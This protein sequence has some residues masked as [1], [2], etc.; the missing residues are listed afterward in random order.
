MRI[1]YAVFIAL[2][3]SA[4][5]WGQPNRPV[6]SNGDDYILGQSS[7]DSANTTTWFSWASV[8]GSTTGSQRY[9]S[10]RTY[11]YATH[12]WSAEYHVAQNPNVDAHGS[13][14]LVGD[15]Y[16][17][18]HAVFGGHA[19]NAKY[20]YTT[21]PND[22]SAWTAGPDISCGCTFYQLLN[23]GGTIYL[24]T[25]NNGFGHQDIY[26]FKGTPSPTGG[27]S[28]WT[29]VTYITNCG[30]FACWFGN[31]IVNGTKICIPFYYTDDVVFD[32]A[33]YGCFDTSNG[34]F[35]NID[36]STV[37]SAGSLPIT[38][39]TAQNDFAVF[40]SPSSLY[41]GFG[42]TQIVD[43]AG[44]LHIFYGNGLASGSSFTIYET[45]WTGSAWSSAVSVTT[46]SN[47]LSSVYPTAAVD[48]GYNLYWSK[49]TNQLDDIWQIHWNPTSGFNSA[50]LLFAATEY[51]LITL[52]PVYDGT[53]NAPTTDLVFGEVPAPTYANPQ[54]ITNPNAR[55]WAHT[56]SG[57]IYP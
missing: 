13:P 4:W 54:P 17:Y 33:Y 52:L 45:H 44:T 11:N 41:T 2:L 28:S 57:Y 53:T 55:F 48:G 21:N 15:Q 30:N 1:L 35:S 25:E 19:S 36:G 26:L 24:L 22:P 46:F 5:T 9:I 6:A 16:G 10:V 40:L 27:I 18:R 37:I 14:A 31:A 51:D 47:I 49:Q 38:R 3:C 34:S 23:V 8:D 56:P 7:Y 20:S 29:G 42:T 12:A 39:T 32:D 50:G 43:G